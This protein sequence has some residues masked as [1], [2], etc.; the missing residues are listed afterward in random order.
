MARLYISND[1]LETWSAENRVSIAGD[2]MTLNEL[3]RSFR[4]VPAVRF[5][6]V[7]G[8]DPDPNELV[9][10]VKS[11]SDLAKM[12]ADHMATSVIFGDTAYDVQQG[13]LGEPL[14]R[15]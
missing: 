13:F 14:P 3:R 7:T 11:E 8:G 9:G 10:T 1:R 5:M 2:V 12:G 4:I 15:A 6:G